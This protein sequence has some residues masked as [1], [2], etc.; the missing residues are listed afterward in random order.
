L[1]N[2]Q[3]VEWI[4]T[5]QSLG[6]SS[7]DV[8]SYLVSKGY[9]KEE[10]SESITYANLPTNQTNATSDINFQNPKISSS[11]QSNFSQENNSSKH[12]YLLMGTIIGIVFILLL[13]VT[14]Y[15]KSID[16]NR[17]E[18]IVADGGKIIN[19]EL[20][21]QQN[22]T[23]PNKVVANNT[24]NNS[25]NNVN[26]TQF[27]SNYQCVDS[28]MCDDSLEYPI[29]FEG[30]CVKLNDALKDYITSKYATSPCTQSCE[31]CKSG[32]LLEAVIGYTSSFNQTNYQVKFCKE[33]YFDDDCRPGF[34]CEL[35]Q[36][37]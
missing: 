5:Q 14:W 25:K 12:H 37:S 10:V 26:V 21:N 8:Y 20:I 6:H 13:A 23:T 28:S 32:K 2:P 7:K 31:N 30:F 15:W 1:K 33:C 11:Q 17:T 4:R 29:C 27:K 22:I 19:P 24:S 16:A 3:L 9:N 34:T 18:G 36:C 35:N